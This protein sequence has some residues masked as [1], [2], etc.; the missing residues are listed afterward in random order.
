M[1]ERE[2]SWKERKMREIDERD[3]EGKNRLRERERHVERHRE[4][5]GERWIE[6][7]G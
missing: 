2:K 3:R 5:D 4:T 6:R 7:D 1:S